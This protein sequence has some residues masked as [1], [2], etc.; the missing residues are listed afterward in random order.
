[1]KYI[2]RRGTAFCL[3]LLLTVTLLCAAVFSVSAKETTQVIWDMEDKSVISQLITADTQKATIVQSTQYKRNGSASL[4]F[5][6][7]GRSGLMG[8]I[9][10]FVD[11]D[12]TGWDTIRFYVNNPT[13]MEAGL[14]FQFCGGMTGNTPF[15]YDAKEIPAHTDGF[16]AVDF[17]LAEFQAIE[18]IAQGSF[19][20][21]AQPYEYIIADSALIFLGPNTGERLYIDDVMLVKAG[22][23]A[24]VATTATTKKTDSTTTTTK[25]TEVTTNT[26]VSETTA[27][28][29]DSSAQTTVAEVPESESE[30]TTTT[31]ATEAVFAPEE[32]DESAIH[33]PKEPDGGFPV[34]AIILIV[35]VVAAAGVGGFLLL[36]KKKT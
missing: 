32:S 4:M 21:L 9:I 34:W 20:D 33:N 17:P 11:V 5:V 14:R 7:T 19:Y 12:L 2:C 3:T 24:S 22:N 15:Y 29:D 10:P 30:L 16:I 27:I 35:V 26:Q 23:D 31:S 25:K 1:M 6:N 36:K 13:D 28:A 8:N 18:Y